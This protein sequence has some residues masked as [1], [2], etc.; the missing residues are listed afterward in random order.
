MTRARPA[1]WNNLRI[2]EELTFSR[3]RDN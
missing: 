2:M 3:A 1:R